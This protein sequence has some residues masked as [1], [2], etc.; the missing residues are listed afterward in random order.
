M[1]IYPYIKKGKEHYFYSFEVQD[2]NG[3]RKTIKK[4]GFKTKGE[5]K[6][7]ERLAQTEW[8]KGSYIDPSKFTVS[9]YMLYW[10]ENKQDLSD[11]S[12]LTYMG[13]MKNHIFPTIGDL[14]LQK[15]NV[16]DIE[17]LIY[18]LNKKNIA[19]GTAKKIFN[20]L[21]TS[22]RVALR[23]EIIARNPIDMLDTGSKPKSSKAKINYWMRD[24]VKE[25]LSRLQHRQRIL[26]ILAIYTGMRRG[27]ICGL[28][29]K[30]IDFDNKQLRI[31]FTL[32]SKTLKRGGKNKNAERSIS[33]SNTV[34]TELKRHRAQIIQER[35]EAKDSY[36]DHDLVVCQ[37]NGN[38][39]SLPNFPRMWSRVLKSTKMR[40]IRF[41]DLRHTCASL[42]LT[43]DVHPKVVQE[44][45]GHSSIKI[46][47]DLYSHLLPNMQAEAVSSLDKML[48]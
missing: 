18:E 46:T 4:R 38:P 25:F 30:D 10:F 48:N 19:D 16:Y 12:R 36:Y 41:H 23:K 28:R 17:K 15:L 37:E 47:L 21:Q 26:F 29:W 35:W 32:R 42:L 43:S 9:Q 6:S 31:R 3:K 8:E 2:R 40:R 11:E 27:E 14:P 1:P 5:A 24:E 7:A 20:I 13:Y 44:L 45:L 22:L 34:I 39:I 33:L